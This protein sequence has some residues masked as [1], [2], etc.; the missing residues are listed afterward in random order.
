MLLLDENIS[1]KLAVRISDEFP[2]TKATS[3]VGALG[4]GA[5]DKSVW[6]Y[7]KANKLV[8]VTKD[9]DFVEYWQRF[10]PPPKVVKLEIGNCRIN[11]IELLLKRNKQIIT[12]FAG[13]SDGLLILKAD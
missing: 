4:E 10:G 3:Q 1:Y 2:S 8:L 5:N 6:D 7:A 13:S 9:K 11:A 12:L